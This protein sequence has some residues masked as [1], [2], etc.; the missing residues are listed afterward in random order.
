[1]YEEA[2]ESQLLDGAAAQEEEHGAQV[3]V[4]SHHDAGFELSDNAP[5]DLSQVIEEGSQE[6]DSWNRMSVQAE[7]NAKQESLPS[8]GNGSLYQ[9]IDRSV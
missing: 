3:A 5:R 1:M 7:Q 2:L 9:P 6:A 4:I 8:A